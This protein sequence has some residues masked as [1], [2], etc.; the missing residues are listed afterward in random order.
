MN[1]GNKIKATSTYSL[2]K[3]LK[4]VTKQSKPSTN[5]TI[6]TVVIN[7][8]RPIVSEAPKQRKFQTSQNSRKVKF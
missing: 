5:A 3:K 8:F 2:N 4:E 7:S 6:K 1:D